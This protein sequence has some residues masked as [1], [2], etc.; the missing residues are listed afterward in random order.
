MKRWELTKCAGLGPQTPLW[1]GASDNPS[2]T[3][4][5]HYPRQCAVDARPIVRTLAA[6]MPWCETTT[7]RGADL[8]F[9]VSTNLKF[10]SQHRTW[11]GTNHTVSCS[12]KCRHLNWPTTSCQIIT[13]KVPPARSVVLS[14]SKSTNIVGG[15]G[16]AG[17]AHEAPQT[18]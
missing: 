8:S 9:K 4:H 15:R 12:F 18:P 10:C 2:C 16:S 14:R 17:G 13:L 6:P 5:Q 3:H 1:D 11:Y 7:P